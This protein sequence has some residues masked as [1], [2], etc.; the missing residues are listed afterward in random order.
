MKTTLLILACFG[1]LAQA[2][3]SLG[4]GTVPAPTEKATNNFRFLGIDL[5]TFLDVYANLS[6]RTVL[7]ASSL[8]SAPLTFKTAKPLT[9]T[10]TLEAMKTVLGK[11]GITLVNHGSNFVLA[12]PRGFT[13][14][15]ASTVPVIPVPPSAQ[16]EQA[17]N[18]A[19]FNGIDI[20]TFL[21]VYG[22][23][24]GRTVM[25]SRSFPAPPITLK[26]V[27]PLTRTDLVEAMTITLELN[28]ISVISQGTNSVQAVMTR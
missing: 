19:D 15:D 21:N 6:D 13:L 17:I 27:K 12:T 11:N 1:L 23:L 28:G 25:H 7:R 26:T 20:D 5:S 4:Q 22:G 16:P 10:D 3:S 8:Q 9:K 24:V 14:A 2:P 18:N